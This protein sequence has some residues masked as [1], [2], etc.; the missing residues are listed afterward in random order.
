ME[1]PGISPESF[2][3]FAEV[4]GLEKALTVLNKN[5]IIAALRKEEIL[6]VLSK[7]DLIA[8]L[9]GEENLLKTLMAELEPE[10]AQELIRQ[11]LQN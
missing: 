6:S 3:R 2:R 10:R 4:I 9:G 5:Q 7:E 8:A 11:R 1:P